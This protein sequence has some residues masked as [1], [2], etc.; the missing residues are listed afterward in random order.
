VHPGKRQSNRFGGCA[1]LRLQGEIVA[2]ADAP[3]A[4]D[5]R[6]YDAL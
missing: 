6:R 3:V 5:R 2:T 1:L 4:F